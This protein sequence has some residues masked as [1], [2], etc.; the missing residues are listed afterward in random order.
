MALIRQP[1]REL[2]QSNQHRASL[3][4]TVGL[5]LCIGLNSFLRGKTGVIM[6]MR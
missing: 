3:I 6:A 5:A 4:L 1:E 2:L